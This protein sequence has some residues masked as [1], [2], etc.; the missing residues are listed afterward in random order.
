M[1]PNALEFLG[2]APNIWDNDS[3]MILYIWRRTV[4]SPWFHSGINYYVLCSEFPC[5]N[6]SDPDI[7]LWLRW[8]N[9]VLF[10]RDGVARLEMYGL[11]SCTLSYLNLDQ[12]SWPRFRRGKS[13]IS[14]HFH[15]EFYGRSEAVEVVKKMVQSCWT[16]WPNRIG[17]VDVSELFGGFVVSCIQCYLLEVFH[18]YITGYR[19]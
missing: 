19:R 10:P 2:N 7:W 5:W 15:C 13:I 3:G 11:A 6:P 18:E 14:F 9:Y 17:V 12:S 8:P 4:T 1:I 16:I